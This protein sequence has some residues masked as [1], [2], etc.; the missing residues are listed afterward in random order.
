MSAALAA[1]VVE[2]ELGLPPERA[3]ARWD[4]QPIAAASIGQ[5]HRAITLDGRAV[6]VK[7]QYPGIAET[8]AADLAN[9][10]LLRRMLRVT[11]PSQDVDALVA[12]L[13]DRV[14]EEL[15]YRLEAD[16]QRLLAAY[17]QGH[18]TIHIPEIIGELSGRRVVTSELSGGARFAELANWSQ[19]ERDL[20]A[21]TIYRFVFR[22]LYEV[23]AFNG[24]PHPGNY[25]FHGGGR[26]TFLDFGLVKHFTPDELR[27][28]MALAR[29]LC[30]ENKPEAFRRSLEDAGFLRPLAP[31][32]TEMIVD[33]L[34]V[35]YATIREP[36]RLTITPDYASTV[37]RRFFD[38]RNP[39]AEYVSIPQ[40]YVIL[41]RIN[42]GLFALLG[43]L[44]ATADWRAI[45]EE[46]W[47]FVRGPAS[48]P[49]GEAEVAWR[50]ARGQPAGLRPTPPT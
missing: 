2:E 35:F 20:A 50:A 26:V 14:L 34:G 47:P 5:V 39:V 19:E 4:P 38:L 3:F 23:H 43:D 16:N 40:S 42:L 15:D 22:S 9:V 18:P 49:L 33:H 29:N 37:V 12:E 1:G 45:A 24:D 11:A 32:S 6:A 17:Y 27:P 7:V 30:V 46:I 41:Q 8:M 21:E 48:T 25:L 31:L 44:T 36:G 10:S 28:L 13:R